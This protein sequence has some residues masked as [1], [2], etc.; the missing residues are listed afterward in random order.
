VPLEDLKKQKV[1][2]EAGG[3]VQLPD[4]TAETL[5]DL[6]GVIGS[7]Y[8]T[9]AKTITGKLGFGQ[10]DRNLEGSINLPLSLFCAGSQGS[11]A[12]GKAVTVSLPS[13]GVRSP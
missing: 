7:C 8:H 9:Y 5:K 6:A 3:A 2:A 12:K 11:Q 1:E 10:K 4:N 13:T